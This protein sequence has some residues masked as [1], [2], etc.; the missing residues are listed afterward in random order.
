MWGTADM[1]SSFKIAPTG[2]V[3]RMISGPAREGRADTVRPRPNSMIPLTR[4][5]RP[6]LGDW[7]TLGRNVPSTHFDDGRSR[8]WRET[9]GQ[10]NRFTGPKRDVV[11]APHDRQ[12]GL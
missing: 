9:P 7:H 2:A 12:Q 10:G 8:S 6:A 3:G 5:G 4:S 1:G 11:V